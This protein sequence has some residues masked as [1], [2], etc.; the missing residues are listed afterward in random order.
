MHLTR[1]G[2]AGFAGS[3]AFSFETESPGELSIRNTGAVRAIFGVKLTDM[4][5]ST[6][7]PALLLLVLQ[8]CATIDPEEFFRGRKYEADKQFRMKA[9]NMDAPLRSQ[10][11]ESQFNLKF[12]KGISLD[13]AVAITPRFGFVVNGAFS[14]AGNAST[15][16]GAMM[17]VI[18]EDGDTELT[19]IPYE[20]ENS[21]EE[22]SVSA[23]LI[24]YQPLG[25]SGR[26][27]QI[28]GIQFGTTDCRY[29][30]VAE[31]HNEVNDVY[32]FMES[33]NWT[34]YYLQQNL[35]FVTTYTEGA[36]MARISYMRFSGQA[37]EE[38][39]PIDHYTMDDSQWVFQPGLKFAAGWKKVRFNLQCSFN[40]PLSGDVKWY[41]A[42]VEG[43]LTFRF[44]PRL[45]D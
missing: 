8:G 12:S 22:G 9:A 7:L 43:G 36:L 31:L 27:E 17:H 42:Q 19:Y 41:G 39:Y 6:C 5:A 15:E 37:F 34:Q 40:L 1:K 20:L 4:K 30:Y 45:N 10:K 24:H 44:G 32:T 28:L 3:C 2:Q 23:G 16:G 14:G 21:L 13:A 25:I 11:G 29:T 18:Y 33:R 35:G 38:A 26:S